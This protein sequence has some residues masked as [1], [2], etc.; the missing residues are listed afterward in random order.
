[1]GCLAVSCPLGESLFGRIKFFAPNPETLK[2][3]SRCTG[4]EDHPFDDRI[5]RSVQSSNSKPTYK[6]KTK[7]KILNRFA[8]MKITALAL[9]FAALASTP[10]LAFDTDKD[11]DDFQF[12]LV[13]S[14]A[15]TA[16]NLLPNAH[17][18][19]KIESV[20]AVEIMKVKVWGLPANTDFDLF[21]IQVP[22][23]PFGL[24]WYQGDIETNK[25]GEGYGEF[26]GRFNIETFIVAPG[27]APAPAD[28]F[29]DPKRILDASLNPPTNPVQLYHL[30]LWFNNPEDVVKAGGPGTITPFN[31]EHDAGIQVL[32]TSEFGDTDGPLKRVTTS[33]N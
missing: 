10:A 27:T 14:P 1:L 22:K 5:R 4:F 25:Y 15:F 12:D 21:V 2:A 17:G 9:A 13:R 8:N 16:L 29:H 20:G 33:G 11:G 24:A 23:A 19:V 6:M 3:Q 26:I 30:G 7:S 31:G 28:P 18:R 32:N